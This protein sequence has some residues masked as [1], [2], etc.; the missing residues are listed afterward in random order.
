MKPNR[1]ERNPRRRILVIASCVIVFLVALGLYLGYE[2]LNSLWL[3]QDVVT[4]FDNQVSIPSGKMVKADVIA[5]EFGIR[6][7]ANLALIDFDAKREE[8]LRKIPN[9][10]AI[11]V[12]RQLPDKV[13]IAIEERE[14]VARMDFLGQKRP[15]GRVVDLEGVVFRCQRGTRLLPVIREKSPPGTAIGH[16]LEGRARAA[17]L[18]IEMTHDAE[19]Q[20]LG[21]LEIDT[22]SP[23][24]L[25]ATLGADYSKLKIAWE[26]MDAKPTPDSR[27][28]LRRQLNHL[29]CAVRAQVGNGVRVW[30]ATDFAKPGRIY[31]D[32]KGP[33]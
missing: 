12:S 11:T 31:A 16:R 24:Y 9:L 13:S 33:L 32:T 19:F 20:D 6:P 22:S 25:L 5:A 17:L 8:I 26:G 3:E 27:S 10:R 21:I 28:S 15:S 7:G 23:D 29:L 4:D 2:K 18:L 30:N 1:I 14:P